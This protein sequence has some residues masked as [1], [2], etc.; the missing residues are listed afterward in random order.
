MSY[1][2]NQVNHPAPSGGG[3]PPFSIRAVVLILV[4]VVVGTAIGVLTFLGGQP[5]PT[6]I[7]AG[8]V[9][10]GAT[11]AAAHRLIGDD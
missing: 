9:A 8:L 11:F 1:P 2:P 6:A 4:S 10:A 7:V 3:R 5:I